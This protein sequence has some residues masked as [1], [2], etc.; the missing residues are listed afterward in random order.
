M[1]V[2]PDVVADKSDEKLDKE[3]EKNYS[4]LI[5]AVVEDYQEAKVR[6]EEEK[7]LDSQKDE[8]KNINNQI[9]CFNVG[10]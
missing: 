10:G 1:P 9:I 4:G 7:V 5:N 2:P 8:L 3:I 6:A